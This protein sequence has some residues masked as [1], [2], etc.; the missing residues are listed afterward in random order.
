LSGF[1]EKIWS[2]GAEISENFDF[3]WFFMEF[4]KIIAQKEPKRSQV[5]N[6]WV[7]RQLFEKY[8]IQ[9]PLCPKI[10]VQRSGVSKNADFEPWLGLLTVT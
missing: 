2:S 1:R 5:G 9:N 6:N 10:Y 4:L 8:K 3:L 7:F